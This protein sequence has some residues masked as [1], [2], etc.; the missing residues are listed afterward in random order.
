M[1]KVGTPAKKKS[2]RGFMRMS[3]HAQ[4]PECWMINNPA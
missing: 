1:S 4:V 3:D 2:V